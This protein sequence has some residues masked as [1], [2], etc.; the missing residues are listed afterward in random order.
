MA[1]SAAPDD[2]SNWFGY[3]R[4]DFEFCGRA[5]LL[6]LPG[7]AASGKPWIWRMRFFGHEPQAD[8]ALLSRGFHV[9]YTD[10]TDLYGGPQA[11]EHMDAFQELMVGEHDLSHKVA[12]EGFSRGGLFALNWGD[13][14]PDRVASIYLDAPV[15]D[16]G[17]WPGGKGSG[18]GSPED[19]EKCKAVYGL[20][21]ETAA[22]FA[23][24][25]VDRLGP[26]AAARIPILSVCGETDTAVPV[27]ENS[28]AVAARLG[29][30]GGEIT[31]IT[32]PHNG[33][34][35]HS[36]Q[37]PTRIVNFVLG[38][39]GMADQLMPAAR[40]PYGYDYHSL[41]GGLESCR[42][43]FQQQKRGRVA[44]LG[45]SIT[46]A[47][48][49]REQVCDDLRRR[50]PDTA[51]EFINAGISSFGST[52]GAF[53][54]ERDLLSHGRIDLL[55]QEAAVNDAANGRTAAEPLRG[56]EGVV[57]HA[58][59]DN[60]Q[61]DLVLL[62]FA[63]PGKIAQLDAGTTPAVIASHEQVAERYAVPS[64]DLAK[65]VAERI[66]AGEFTWADDF[67]DLHP[68]P[69][70][71]QL[72][73]GSVSRLL[74]AVWAGSAISEP[75]AHSLPAQLDQKSYV[76]GRLLDVAQATADDGWRLDPAWRAGDGVSSRISDVP[77]L[78]C[79]EPGPRLRLAFQGT[80]VGL[81]L[82][83]GPDAGIL[84]FSIDGSPVEQRDLFTAWSASLHL[85]CVQVLAA[86]LD[87]GE[88]ELVLWLAPASN[89]KSKGHAVRIAHFAAN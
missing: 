31:V 12:L 20:T 16:I 66:H 9:A 83:A 51:F 69:F 88:H 34:H 71:H 43:I 58:R 30:L 15:C 55:F 76:R 63:D 75:V 72:Y 29:E 81:Y 61:I 70:G 27:A 56:M 54:L 28:R 82:A 73:A 53:R 39:V 33:H 44:F 50:F 17:S 79:E 40:T 59:L 37:D 77:M 4:I 35:P 38:Q 85:N 47:G 42:A 68:S 45:G 41:R 22:T 46:F 84:E 80:A 24:N 48:A 65:E 23:D 52:P 49:W 2:I 87:S 14:H 60:P 67:K 32:K 21:E 25:P 11:M 78:I 74:D 19:W 7:A 89:T 86:D 8:I 18:D 13:R 26:I 6:V 64:I 3:Q 10:M 62:H 36:L 5:S 1:I 57:R